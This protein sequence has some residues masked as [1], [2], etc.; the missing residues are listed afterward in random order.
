[1][2]Q[3]FRVFK[4]YMCCCCKQGWSDPSHE[5]LVKLLDG[6]QRT[7]L[8][9]EP[10]SILNSSTWVRGNLSNVKGMVRYEHT[11]S[12]TR[13]NHIIELTLEELTLRKEIF[14]G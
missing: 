3:T 6:L 11:F 4:T 14:N 7:K 5:R 9:F 13:Y 1:M 12:H 2:G 8:V 10:I